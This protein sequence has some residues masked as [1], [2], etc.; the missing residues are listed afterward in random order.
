MKIDDEFASLIPALTE[1]EYKRLEA[2]ILNEGCRDAIVLWG[3]I[4]I[5]GHNRYKICSEHNIEFS[6]IQKEFVSRDEVK[7][8][9]LQNQLSRRNLNDFQ[10][11]E[12]VR[13]CEDAIK[14]QAKER[15]LSGLA[16]NETTVR[17]N[18]PERENEVKR[19]TEEL[20]ELAGVSRK[21]YEHAVTVL[22]QAPE[23]VIQATRDK[24]LSI[25][26]AFE[27]TKLPKEQQT[28]IA[29]R[30][31][32]GE[33]PKV[34]VSSVRK[35]KQ[36]ATDKQVE[37]EAGADIPEA[38]VVEPVEFFGASETLQ[39]DSETSKKEF[40]IIELLEVTETFHRIMEEG[41]S[42]CIM[43]VWLKPNDMQKLFNAIV[44]TGSEFKYY[45][46]AFVWSH[47]GIIKEVC[48]VGTRGK[49]K[50]TTDI[51]PRVIEAEAGD[52]EKHPKLFDDI[53][54]SMF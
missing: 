9:M 24:E 28:E 23:A 3:E 40:I 25:N 19:A 47:E 29:E 18:L 14:A 4:I 52:D 20:G 51:Q 6:T 36:K 27:I 42:D 2:S 43:F 12:M 34:V 10:R 53:V 26:A 32:Q 5:D 37:N 16:Q 7:L 44:F 17:E 33:T 41:Q 46:I 48:V 1:D 50:I 11:V 54:N 22:D 38:T 15:Q 21:T 31:E 13:R 8:W 35:T 30:I 49:A 45:G 39:T